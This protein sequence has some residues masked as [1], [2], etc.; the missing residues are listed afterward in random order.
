MT[1]DREFTVDVN[2][3]IYGE[4]RNSSSPLHASCRDFLNAV[5]CHCNAYLVMDYSGKIIDHYRI[6]LRG[7]DYSWKFVQQLMDKGRVRHFHRVRMSGSLR[8]AL[9]SNGCHGEDR[10]RYVR[11]AAASHCRI[12]VTHDRGFETAQRVLR[13]S[14]L[15][16]FPRGSTEAKNLMTGTLCPRCRN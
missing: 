3:L 16:V 15:E 10:E 12:L 7:S 13:R 4:G 5:Q 9:A 2:V 1:A 8:A 6:K 14:P 11:T